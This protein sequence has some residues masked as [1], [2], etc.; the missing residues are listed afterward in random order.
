MASP[1]SFWIRW[2]VRAGYPAAL[3]YVLLAKPSRI[4]FLIGAAVGLVGIAIRAWAAGYLHK[5]EVLA[6]YGPYAFT[7]NPLYFGSAVLAAGFVL[8]GDSV[9]AGAIVGIY[10]LL[11]YPAVMRREENELL[12]RYGEEFTAYAARI[13]LFWP[14]LRFPGAGEN[15]PAR[16]SRRLYLQNREYQ[17]AF[18]FV[19]GLAVLWVKMRWMI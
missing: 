11:F 13:P 10:L 3:V 1:P 15:A 17:A 9:C 14:R 18:G 2:R 16:F 8:A 6:T 5:H 12:E 19:L 7:R 4:S